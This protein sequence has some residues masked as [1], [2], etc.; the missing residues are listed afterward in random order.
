MSELDGLSGS[1]LRQKLEEALAELATLR[2]E[3]HSLK[4][5]ALISRADLNL[6]KDSDLDGV[7]PDSLEST[8]KEIQSTRQAEQVTLL[9]KAG[10]DE[11]A[12]KKVVA[13]ES[14]VGDTNGRK[15]EDALRRIQVAGRV[16]GGEKPSAVPKEG[17]SGYDAIRQHF[18]AQAAG[19]GKP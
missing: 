8:A 16:G 13:G 6:V 15:A 10:L 2:G 3:N 5:Q 9:M 4:V 17:F 19:N 14:A 1:A 11:E 18:A 12:A 7:D